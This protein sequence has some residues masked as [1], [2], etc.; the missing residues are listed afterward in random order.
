MGVSLQWLMSIIGE[1][2]GTVGRTSVTGK[3][4]ESIGMTHADGT[5]AG[6]ANQ[7][8]SDERTL[9][10]GATEDLDL[11][12]TSLQSIFGA[13]LAIAEIVGLVIYALPTN[14]TNLTVGAAAS[15]AWVGALNA[16]G[17]VTLRP[18]QWMA[19]GCASS[20]DATGFPVVATTGDLLKI[21]NAA[22]ASAKYRIYALG[23]S[24]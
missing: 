12:G 4:Q 16:A 6:Q 21:A 23:R 1:V 10:T 5:G 19:L 20:S 13:A 7:Y 22:G 18:G 17:T 3:I 24:A 2:T 11:S 15:N 9:T 14:T 8:A